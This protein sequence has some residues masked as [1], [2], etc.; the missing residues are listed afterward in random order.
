MSVVP[1]I[2]NGITIEQMGEF[3][4]PMLRKIV[5]QELTQILDKQ[6]DKFLSPKEVCERFVPKISKTTL[7][8]WTEQGL[9]QEYRLG[10][11]VFYL[12][13]EIVEKAKTLKKYK[14]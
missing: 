3:L 8:S 11:R 10:S 2:L 1:I 9:L 14:K 5:H 12:F 13:S 4:E 6:E 7:A